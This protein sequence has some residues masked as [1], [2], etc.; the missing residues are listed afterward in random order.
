MRVL[1]VDWRPEV[2]SSSFHGRDLFAPVAAM[3]CEGRLPPGSAIDRGA[4]I[5]NDWPDELAK[6]IPGSLRPVPWTE[7]PTAQV[8]I[9]L[10]GTDGT[11]YYWAAAT[12]TL[13]ARAARREKLWQAHR[14]HLYQ[15]ASRGWASHAKVS[16][17]VGGLG[18][19]LIAL[20]AWSRAA[21][22]PALAL[23]ALATLALILG[24]A[25]IGRRVLGSAP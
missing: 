18:L 2:L 25:R 24:F 21:P 8:M 9:T 4:L 17:A 20:A 12:L 6:V 14:S 1:R 15:Q 19:V 11:P 13:L 16:L 22:W 5:G 10:E 3:L 23:A 7:R